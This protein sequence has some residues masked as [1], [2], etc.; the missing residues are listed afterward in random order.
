M[1]GQ[2]FKHCCLTSSVIIIA[3]L[4]HVAIYFDY[5]NSNLEPVGNGKCMRIS[6]EANAIGPEDLTLYDDDILLA[7]SDYKL[8]LFEGYPHYHPENI[9]SGSIVAIYPKLKLL[10][11]LT[12]FGYPSN[13]DFRPHGIYL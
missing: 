4:L 1:I 9:P 13:V 7:G 11:R 10:K 6:N 2:I 12:I 5:L 3:Y 8:E